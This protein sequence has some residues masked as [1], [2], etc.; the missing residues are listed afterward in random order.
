MGTATDATGEPQRHAAG[1]REQPQPEHPLAQEE[2]APVVPCKTPVPS[3]RRRGKKARL[4]GPTVTLGGREFS[5][6][7]LQAFGLNPK[8]LHFRQLDRQ[9]RKQQGPKSRP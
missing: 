2:E 1:P 4:L 3:K 8:R 7:R 5:R 9:R 6:Q